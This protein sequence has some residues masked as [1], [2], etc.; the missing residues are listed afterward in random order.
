MEFSLEKLKQNNGH[1]KKN[2]VRITKNNGALA[3]IK[4]GKLISSSS[5]AEI[6]KRVESYAASIID[7]TTEIMKNTITDLVFVIDISTSTKGL[8]GATCVGYNTLI[9]K[10]KQSGFNTKVTTVLFGSDVDRIGFRK[11]IKNVSSLT[12]TPYGATALFDAIADTI[13]RVRE[14]QTRDT[15]QTSHTLFYIMTDG[16]IY[17]GDE[18]SQ[19]YS[20][21]NVR[22]L[23]KECQDLGWEFLFLG[24]LDNAEKIASDLGIKGNNSVEIEKSQEGMYNSFVSTSQALDELRTYGK[25]TESWANVSKKKSASIEDK[26]QKRLGLK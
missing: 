14:D 13:I 2:E 20:L 12:Y 8:E 7:K 15:E 17:D 6:D 4:S 10:E 16:K 9:A 25:L 22:Q 21:A 26:N 5:Q 1:A 19:E 23:I 3:A 18:C 24:A 11:D